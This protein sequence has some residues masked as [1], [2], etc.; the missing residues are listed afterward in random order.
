MKILNF[1]KREFERNK[2]KSTISTTKASQ[3]LIILNFV[4]RKPI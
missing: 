2:E 1:R 3:G 4:L